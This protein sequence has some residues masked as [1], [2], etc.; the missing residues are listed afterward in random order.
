VKPLEALRQLGPGA[1][2]PPEV[3]QRVRL[4]VALGLAPT[5][6]R[7]AGNTEGAAPPS[8]PAAPAL[9][10]WVPAAM[11]WLATAVVTGALLGAVGFATFGPERVRIVYVDRPVFTASASPSS[12]GVVG[13]ATNARRPDDAVDMPSMTPAPDAHVRAPK[14]VASGSQRKPGESGLS[15]ERS[16]LDQA[17]RYMTEGEPARALD[18]TSRHERDFPNGKLAEEREAMAIRALLALG[19]LEEARARGGRFAARFPGSLLAPA[20]EPAFAPP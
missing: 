15:G 4:G 13:P 6:G 5:L 8:A 17:R 1:E 20:L 3:K 9:G 10:A 18:V 11:P 7:D 14:A 16:L 2:P 19:N 12:L